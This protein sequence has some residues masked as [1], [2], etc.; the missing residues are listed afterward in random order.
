MEEATVEV[1]L[2]ADKRISQ[3]EPE[4]EQSAEKQHPETSTTQNQVSASLLPSSDPVTGFAAELKDNHNNLY[5]QENI[6]NRQD[7]I[8][9]SVNL[10]CYL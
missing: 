10:S 3:P 7:D 1:E 4:S 2:E 5:L 9:C 8:N 6:P